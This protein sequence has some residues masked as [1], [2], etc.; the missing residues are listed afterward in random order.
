MQCFL[1]EDD[2]R[3]NLIAKNIIFSAHQLKHNAP[4]SIE[5]SGN[6]RFVGFGKHIPIRLYHDS[7][8]GIALKIVRS[9]SLQGST[10]IAKFFSSSCDEGSQV[11]YDVL[12][13]GSIVSN[14]TDYTLSHITLCDPACCDEALA[15]TT[16]PIVT[17]IQSIQGQ[18]FQKTIPIKMV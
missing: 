11:I 17:R 9:K 14:G 4:I 5:K 1:I 15:F 10:D 8:L 2:A 6:I 13:Y 16:D 12:T 3:S 18:S 7:S